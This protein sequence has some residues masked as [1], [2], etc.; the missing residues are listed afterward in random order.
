MQ[1]ARCNTATRR[2]RVITKIIDAECERSGT[3]ISVEENKVV[4]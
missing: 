4:A 2:V 1:Q 3:D